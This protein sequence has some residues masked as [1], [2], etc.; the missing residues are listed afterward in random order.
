MLTNGFVDAVNNVV[1]LEEIKSLIVVF[2]EISYEMQC[3]LFENFT[4][5]AQTFEAYRNDSTLHKFMT[6]LSLRSR[7]MRA[8]DHHLNFEVLLGRLHI[9]FY[10]LQA[11]MHEK[12][13]WPNP[14]DNPID[15][16]QRNQ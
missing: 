4:S 15:D 12:I 6:I 13:Y 7:K 10:G 1:F 2:W 8:K 3:L 14:I 9:L 16:L 11:T 5:F